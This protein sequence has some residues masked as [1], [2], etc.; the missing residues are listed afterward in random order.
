MFQLTHWS[1]R[2]R[3]DKHK[4]SCIP[5]NAIQLFICKTLTVTSPHTHKSTH[6]Y[7]LKISQCAYSCA[8]PYSCTLT[9]LWTSLCLHSH[10]F[11]LIHACTHQY[12]KYWCITYIHNGTHTNTHPHTPVHIITLYIHRLRV[13]YTQNLKIS[14]SHT[15]ATSTHSH[16]NPHT[17]NHIRH[18]HI[19]LHSCRL[20]DSHI[21]PFIY[22]F[23]SNWLPY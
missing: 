2:H 17:P 18:S 8:H 7:T 9:L 20:T 19:F 11:T 13:P 6:T 14:H 21:V 10:T 3:L 15:N 1:D 5:R 12:S 22:I 16:A 4:Y 23:T